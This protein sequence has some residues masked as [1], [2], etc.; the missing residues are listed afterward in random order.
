MHVKIRYRISIEKSREIT[1]SISHLS[2]TLIIHISVTFPSISKNCI[3]YHRN[4]KKKDSNYNKW[5]KCKLTCP[6]LCDQT[7]SGA[8]K[9]LHHKK[10]QKRIK[11]SIIVIHPCWF[12]KCAWKTCAPSDA[13]V[14]DNNTSKVRPIK[15][16]DDVAAYNTSRGYEN[17]RDL[18][19]DS[20]RR[21]RVIS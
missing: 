4:Q 15:R 7:R 9:Y 3:K 6:I 11:T 1:Y 13:K 20:N 5:Y 18:I 10:R 17:I 16:R 2:D 14:R 19:A 8:R 12:R 21:L